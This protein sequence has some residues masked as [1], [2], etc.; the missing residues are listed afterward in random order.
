MVARVHRLQLGHV[1]DL[2]FEELLAGDLPFSALGDE[3]ELL[4][5]LVLEAARRP[6]LREADASA[7]LRREDLNVLRLDDRSLFEH[8]LAVGE[9]TRAI[10]PLGARAGASNALEL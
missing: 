6:H 2:R 5:A 1:R 3:H 10:E 4:R 9:P 7:R 8:A